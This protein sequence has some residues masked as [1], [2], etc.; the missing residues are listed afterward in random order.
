MGISFKCK[1]LEWHFET[2]LKKVIG[3]LSWRLEPTL[4]LNIFIHSCLTFVLLL[5]IPLKVSSNDKI[6]KNLEQLSLWSL[7]YVACFQRVSFWLLLMI[8]G[9]TTH[10]HYFFSKV[11]FKI[12]IVGWNL[13]HW[14]SCNLFSYE[15]WQLYV[16]W[17]TFHKIFNHFCYSCTKCYNPWK[18]G[19]S[20]QQTHLRAWFCNEF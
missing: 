17:T 2:N 8:W 15:C 4:W 19:G 13:H 14:K 9:L 18:I 5:L 7:G 3:H 20:A 11:L 6:C 1:T 10:G 12:C 16:W